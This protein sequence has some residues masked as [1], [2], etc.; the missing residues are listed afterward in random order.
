MQAVVLHRREMRA[1]REEGDVLACRRQPAAEIAADAARPEDR[2]LHSFTASR[3]T[4]GSSPIT[5]GVVHGAARNLDPLAGPEHLRVAAHDQAEPARQHRVD[6]VD[7]MLVIGKDRAGLVDVPRDAIAERF[8]LGAKG[9]FG[10]RPVSDGPF[11][12]VIAQAALTTRLYWA[13]SVGEAGM[14]GTDP[15]ASS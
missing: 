14:P 2:D 5:G 12:G 8:E 15:P 6:L 3:L 1:A 13:A 11:C 9:R 7:V 4:T 10:Q